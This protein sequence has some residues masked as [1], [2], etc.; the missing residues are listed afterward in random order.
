MSVTKDP[1]SPFYRYDFVINRRRFFGSTKVTTERE[2]K[3]VERIERERAKKQ[4]AQERAA[5]T[6]LRLDDVAGRYW[7]EIGQHHAGADNTERQ[8]DL[9]IACPH[10]GPDIL[11]TDITGDHVAKLV[12]WRRGHRILRTV[13]MADGKRRKEPG[14]LIGP[15]AVNDTIEQLKKL[16]T[17][18]KALGVRFDHEPVW[19]DHWLDEPEERVRELVGDEHARLEA[20]TRD[21]YAPFFAF[22]HATGMRW[23]CEARVLRWSEVNWRAKRIVMLGKG[24]K[25]VTAPIT[26]QVRAILW[27]LRGHHDEFVFTYVAQ[28]TR[29]KEGLVKGQRYPLTKNGTKSRW[30]RQRKAA[31]VTDFRMHDYRHD[32]GTKVLRDTGNLKLTSRAMNHASVTTTARY[33]HVLDEDVA[34][35]LER[36]SQSPNPSPNRNREAS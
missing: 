28:R 2:A 11:M 18:C 33:A 14:R 9:L 27:P 36:R 8:L 31:G 7:L 21:D 30:S 23:N 34:A 17:R 13:R 24:G 6:S 20:A 10:L 19:K 1:R 5:A 32:F 16:F 35:A 29:K 15:F 22:V 26:S 4:I 12:A 3:G 25:R